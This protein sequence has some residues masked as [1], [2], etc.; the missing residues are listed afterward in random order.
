VAFEAAE[1]SRFDRH[2]SV[3]ILDASGFDILLSI[4]QTYDIYLESAAAFL[5]VSPVL[6]P[7]VGMNHD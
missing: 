6:A 1:H 4:Q 5:L 7:P 3:E 2:R